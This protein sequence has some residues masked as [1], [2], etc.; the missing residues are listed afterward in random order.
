MSIVVTGGAGFIGSCIVRKLNDAGRTD[1]IVVDNIA[2]TDK[3]MNLRNK[4]YIAYIHKSR[5]LEILYSGKDVW[6][7]GS[8]AK[9]A[10][11][12]SSGMEDIR[13]QDIEA[14]IHMGAQ[15][16]TAEKNFDYLWENNFA[17]TKALWEYCCQKQIQFLYASSAATYGDGAFG[18]DDK[19]G[20][21][22]LLPLNAYGYSKQAFDLWVE[23]QARG[24]PKQYAGF[25]FFN[26]Y[27]PNEYFK[28]DMA[29]MVFHGYRQICR[30]GEIRLFRSYRLE[31]GDGGQCRDFVYVKDVCD[32][33]LWFLEH[34]DKSGLFNVGTGKAQSFA[35]LAGAV[36]HALGRE[37]HIRYIDM[38]EQLKEKYQYYTQADISKLREAGY[39][40][41]FMD[42][43]AGARDY[44]QKYL[45]AGF[46]IY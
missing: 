2:S 23:H 14:V 25:K 41:A 3:W 15:S 17:Y 1:I 18:F 43:E 21:D 26:V 45:S 13:M 9:D 11:M 36:F 39:T 44:V 28:Q 5:F 33:V 6:A 31:Y 42:V 22:Q 19:R 20:I 40:A 34:P 10:R 29:S 37:P 24:F 4:K 46:Q 32:V 30:D 8:R 38:P 7:A 35:Q 16:S 27:G 12:E